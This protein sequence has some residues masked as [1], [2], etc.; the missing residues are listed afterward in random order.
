MTRIVDKINNPVDLG[1]ELRALRKRLG[2]KSVQLSKDSGRSRDVLNRL[3]RGDEVYV[4]S[5]F[6]AL[7]AM[8][9]SIR[10]EKRG[11]PSLAE[12]QDYTA[13]ELG[14]DGER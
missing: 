6:D 7:R 10:L 5:L 3:E 2:I 1:R 8:G 12:M 11:L 9:Y 13:R 14:E 4:S